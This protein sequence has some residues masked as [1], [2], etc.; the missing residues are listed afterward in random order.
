MNSQ[1]Q[2]HLLNGIIEDAMD[3]NNKLWIIFQ[4]MAKAFNSMGLILLDK[5]MEQ[6]KILAIMR[7]FIIDLFNNRQIRVITKF[8]L[9]ETFTSE[10]SIN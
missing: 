8:G 10:N 2:I 3:N 1:I 9:S 4:N 5:A 6:I 7:E